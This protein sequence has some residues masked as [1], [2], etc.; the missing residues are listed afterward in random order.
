MR[1]MGNVTLMNE[2]SNT[3]M[4]LVEK[5]VGNRRLGKLRRWR[6][7]S[8]KIYVREIWCS[9]LWKVKSGDH[10]WT[11]KWSSRFLTILGNSGVGE[12]LVA[13]QEELSSMEFVSYTMSSSSSS[14]SSI[15][16][17]Q[18]FCHVI[19]SFHFFEFGN[20]NFFTEQVRNPAS[21]PQTGRLV[22][23]CALINKG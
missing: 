5:H 8:I 4:V 13:S 2:K 1:L 15:V 3:F 17:Q 18:Q 16:K 19:S 6:E 21:N 22:M 14:L 12:R 9:G 7:T 10:S 20:S 23:Q 11:L